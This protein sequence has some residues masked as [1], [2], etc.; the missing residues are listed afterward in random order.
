MAHIRQK[1]NGETYIRYSNRDIEDAKNISVIDFL[2]REYGYDFIRRGRY[3][4]CRQHDSL[5]IDGNNCKTW[6]WNS[7]QSENGSG[8][9]SGRNV[10]DWLMQTEG[11]NFSQCLEKLVPTPCDE[12]PRT[13]YS[14]APPPDILPIDEIKNIELPQKLDGRFTRSAA[15][16]TKTRRIDSA[17]VGYIIDNNLLYEDID[18]NAVFVGHDENGEIKFAES[19]LT[20]TFLAEKRDENGKKLFHPKNVKGSDKRYSFNIPV[21]EE[22][23][24]RSAGILYVFEAPV[25]LLSHCTFAVVNE[26][27]RAERENERPNLN[28]WRNVNRLSLSGCSA[29]ALDAYLERNPQINKIVFA[30]DFDEVG[31]KA[32]NRMAEIYTEKGYSCS[33]IRP[34]KGKD[35]NEYLQMTMAEHDNELAQNRPKENGQKIANGSNADR[36][37]HTHSV[38]R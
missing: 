15:Y 7:Q 1:R 28:C 35:F 25:D 31:I 23:Y 36:Y 18:H 38:H 12:I 14:K 22:N 13:A 27:A 5:M 30:L 29:V 17:V 26:R 16:L 8:C 3:Y 2:Q 11:W 21:D 24:P 34:I 4:Q 20:N 19:K 9:M 6:Y 10:F 37:I 33:K 32:A